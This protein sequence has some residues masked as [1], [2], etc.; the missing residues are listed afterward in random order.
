VKVPHLKAVAKAFAQS[1]SVAADKYRYD[2]TMFLLT[3]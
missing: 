2:L 3:V 1:K